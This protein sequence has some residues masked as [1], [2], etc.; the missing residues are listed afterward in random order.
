MN[1]G[2]NIIDQMK[3][4]IIFLLLGGIL[5]LS[6]CEQKD[7]KNMEA[8]IITFEIVGDGRMLE[9]NSN[10]INYYL[11]KDINITNLTP[12]ITISENATIFPSSNTPQDFSQPVRYTVTSEDGNYQQTYTI[13]II[14][15]STGYSE[16]F[17]KWQEIGVGNN[18]YLI[19][20]GWSSGNDGV[21]IIRGM[22]FSIAYPTFQTQHAYA[23]NYAV[24]METQQGG[25]SSII[26][27]IISGSL[28]LGTF[29][30]AT[31]LTN[32]LQCPRFG[33]PYSYNQ[34][35]DTLFAY[36]Q[37]TPGNNYQSNGRQ[38]PSITDRC[39]FY[40][41][42][43]EGETPLNASNAHTDSRIIAKA[44]LDDTTPISSTE[45]TRVAIP[46]VYKRAVP[47]NVKLQFSIIASSS[48]DGDFYKG[49]PG[50]LLF[51]DQIS[52]T[53]K[54]KP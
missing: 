21:K 2:M 11:S 32:P 29:N 38:E 34:I 52:I 16:D 44:V 36:L 5:L 26:P 10:I 12:K 45:Y 33:V 47:E 20:I 39:A 4:I 24:A 46:F 30:T 53:T 27:N 37:Y 43:F 28:F 6:G 50:S 13:N 19:P 51:V 41:I 3:S 22:G 1:N 9:I 48:K 25:Q 7:I 8:D 31:A 40:A 49:A 42:F 23:G 14:V 18:K 35:P 17:E 15:S 54:Q